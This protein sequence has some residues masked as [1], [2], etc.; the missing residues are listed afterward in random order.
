[1]WDYLLVNYKHHSFFGEHSY[2]RMIMRQMAEPEKWVDWEDT[3][4]CMFRL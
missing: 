3:I 2:S 1:M 4:E